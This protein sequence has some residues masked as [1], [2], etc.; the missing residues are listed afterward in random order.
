[1]TRSHGTKLHILVS[2]LR[3]G[4]YKTKAGAFSVL[5]VPLGNLLTSIC[6]FVLCDRVVHRA[7]SAHVS[8]HG[9]RVNHVINV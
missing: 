6:N 8:E 3:S 2:K 9:R 5:G 7:Y 4:T 1:M